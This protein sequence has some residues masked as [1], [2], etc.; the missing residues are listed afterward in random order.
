[1]QYY[2]LQPGGVDYRSFAKIL[3][4]RLFWMCCNHVNREDYFLLL[5]HIY[6]YNTKKKKEKKEGK[7]NRMIPYLFSPL[8]CFYNIDGRVWRIITLLISAIHFA[9]SHIDIR[10]L[11]CVYIYIKHIVISTLTTELGY[12]ILQSFNDYQIDN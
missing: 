10:V 8:S 2:C 4:H 9:L 11:A 6:Y 7:A 5:L 1:M 12:N 3:P